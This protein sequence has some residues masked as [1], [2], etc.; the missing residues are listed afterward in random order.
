MGTM[1]DTKTKEQRQTD[2]NIYT[3]RQTKAQAG[4]KTDIHT[5]IDRYTLAVTNI[6][7]YADK[8]KHREIDKHIHTYKDR[9]TETQA[10]RRIYLDLQKTP[11]RHRDI[12]SHRRIDKERYTHTQTERD[13]H[14]DIQTN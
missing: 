4:E 13:R 12:H 1:A 3:H 11:G 6:Q 14:Q 7:R 9:Q 8:H 2:T 5:P 10:E